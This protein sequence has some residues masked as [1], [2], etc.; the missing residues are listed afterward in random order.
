MMMLTRQWYDPRGDGRCHHRI[1]YPP[2]RNMSIINRWYITLH[3][4]LKHCKSTMTRANSKRDQNTKYKYKEFNT[5]N[6]VYW[7]TVVYCTCYFW[8]IMGSVGEQMNTAAVCSHW[9]S[10]QSSK[11][12]FDYYSD[13]SLDY[14]WSEH[15]NCDLKIFFLRNLIWINIHIQ[16][17]FF[18]GS[19]QTVLSMEL[20]PHNSKKTTKYTGSAQYIK[21]GKVSQ[22]SSYHLFLR[23]Y[24][25]ERFSQ[26]SSLKW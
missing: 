8:C 14:L 25:G 13:S 11:N 7:N 19:A 4:A 3:S 10:H 23:H 12:Y 1:I 9:Y 24:A 16:G 5:K 20:V 21:N 6:K 26:V 2:Q 15:K 22:R 18:T 17:V